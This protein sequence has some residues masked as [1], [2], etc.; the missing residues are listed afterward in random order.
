MIS[1]G[2]APS[3]LPSSMWLHRSA[4]P[5]HRETL[6]E[7]NDKGQSW[8]CDVA[9]GLCHRGP[10]VWASDCTSSK[11]DP[12]PA[13][14]QG[15]W[16]QGEDTMAWLYQRQRLA[17]ALPSLRLVGEPGWKGLPLQPWHCARES[18]VTL[19]SYKR[20]GTDVLPERHYIRVATGFYGGL[21]SCVEMFT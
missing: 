21:E 18:K 19:G 16:N 15:S 5:N 2:L 12:K 7:P 8:R 11:W 6:D 1:H 3:P 13:S 4:K 17:L 14:D 10:P 20:E 9:P